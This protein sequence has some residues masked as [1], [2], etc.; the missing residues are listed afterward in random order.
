[1]L[2]FESMNKD[3]GKRGIMTRLVSFHYQHYSTSAG[4]FQ[5]IFSSAIQTNQEISQEHTKGNTIN[6]D[7]KTIFK[8]RINRLNNPINTERSVIRNI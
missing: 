8:R 3:I 5:G 1:M 6:P 2:G 4:L 7:F